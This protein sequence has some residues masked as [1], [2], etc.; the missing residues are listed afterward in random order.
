MQRDALIARAGSLAR[1]L[2]DATVEES[3]PGDQSICRVGGEPFAVITTGAD[4]GVTVKIEPL[5]ALV[6]R[7]Q[8]P[9]IM[10]GRFFDTKH[11]ITIPFSSEITGSVIEE[12]IRESYRLV[13]AGLSEGQLRK[14]GQ[15]GVA[16]TS[17]QLQSLAREVARGLPDVTSGRPFVEKLEVFK[18]SGKVFL[19]VTDDPDEPIVTVK[20]EP[21]MQEN[22]SFLYPTITAGRYLDKANWISIGAGNGVTAN[23]VT[24]L[25]E[26]SCSLVGKHRRKAKSLPSL[27]RGKD[28]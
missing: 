6:R 14:S 15:S 21:A 28:A 26:T 12:E 27:P 3:L 25:V 5:R 24:E 20:A 22:L 9:D 1:E 7:Q 8:Y 23:L 17:A 2:P 19:I 10:D 16:L 4:A 18:A 11:W 13:R